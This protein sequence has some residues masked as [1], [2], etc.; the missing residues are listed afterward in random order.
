M[1]KGLYWLL[2]LFFS[3]N[4]G[5]QSFKIKKITKEDFDEKFYSL[6]PTASAVV[7]YNVGST[8]FIVAGNNYQLVTE[9]KTRIKIFTKEAYNYATVN[10]PLYRNRSTRELLSVS[11][12]YTYNL[13]D[14][15]VERTKLNTSGEFIEK[16]QGNYY[17]ASFTMPNVK[18]GSIIEYTT[19]ITSPYITSIPEWYFQYDIPVKI[20]EFE[21]KFPQRFT[22]YKYIKGTEKVNQRIIGDKYVYMANNIPALKEE[23]FV[24][25]IN[26]YRTSIIH[27]FSGFQEKNGTS[28]NFG[29]T[30]EE[31]VKTINNNDNF[32][33]Q[34]K[35]VNFAKSQAVS[36]VKNITS[37]LDKAD[38]IVAFLQK[39]VTWNQTLGI[40][41]SKD[42]K[43]V[44]QSKNGNSA[45]I[46]LL[47]IAMMRSVDVNAYP[48]LLA[49]RSKGIAYMPSVS[50]FNNVIIGV[51]SNTGSVSLFDATDKFSKKDILPI[52]NLNWIGRLVRPDGTSKDVLL[53]PQIK[54]RQSV[55]A[56][57]DLNPAE[58]SIEGA[59]LCSMNNYKA[60]LFRREND[61]LSTDKIADRYEE[62]YKAEIDSLAIVNFDD[63]NENIIEKITLK[64]FHS[65]DIIGDKIYLT[66]TFIFK[67]DE[68]PFKLDQRTYPLDFIYPSD[69]NY[70]L[71]YNIPEGFEVEYV[72]ESKKISTGTNSVAVQWTIDYDENQIRVRWRL[73]QNKAYV[74]AGEYPDIKVV[75][76]ELIKFMDEKVVLKRK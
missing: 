29:G 24:N 20:S 8:F 60:F 7:D 35:N 13:V 18:E 43:E 72:P 64:R 12:A 46:N 40:R 37:D 23:S 5:A 31:V 3:V 28:K 36:L 39:E 25:N 22:F 48:I 55:N 30:W 32:G 19:K 75:Y 17:L 56:L 15:K 57:L 66:P 33:S 53:E 34:L 67:Q 76:E 47:A 70:T 2:L 16:I 26:N 58:G 52:H 9:T 45:D 44:L 11:D 69:N 41:T 4:L 50:A 62:R 63:L 14:G 65:F 68:N 42:L 74:D 71:I 49:T 6:D 10:I 59:L 73:S 61:Q 21:L 27:T 51:E 38:A 54:S 1:N